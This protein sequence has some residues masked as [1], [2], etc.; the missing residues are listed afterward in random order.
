MFEST[1]PKGEPITTLSFCL[2]NISSNINIF[3]FSLCCNFHKFL[4]FSPCH[5]KTKLLSLNNLLQHNSRVSFHGKILN[6]DS[7]CILAK[8]LYICFNTSDVK[9]VKVA[10][11][12]ESLVVYSLVSSV[13]NRGSKNFG[14]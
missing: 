5:S 4:K 11:V 14:T 2:Q 10:K 12:N 7:I 3:S 9:K 6:N 13:F 1:G 8:K